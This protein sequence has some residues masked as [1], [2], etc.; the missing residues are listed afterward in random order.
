MYVGSIFFISDFL[1]PGRIATK[2]LLSF[3]LNLFI[4]SSL[5]L[6]NKFEKGCPR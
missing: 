3:K 5:S 6:G 2:F 1:L 4:T